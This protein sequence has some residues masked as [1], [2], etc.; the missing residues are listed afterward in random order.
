VVESAGRS[1]IGTVVR[2]GALTPVSWLGPQAMSMDADAPRR[3]KLR[4]DG[5]GLMFGA[6]PADRR[7]LC[8]TPTT[9]AS[10]PTC[11]GVCPQP[12]LDRV[13]MPVCGCSTVVDRVPVEFLPRFS[14]ARG[15]GR[16]S[17][18]RAPALHAGGR[19]FE[20]DR[21]H[22]RECSW[23]FGFQW[24]PAPTRGPSE[25]NK[26]AP[27]LRCDPKSKKHLCSDPA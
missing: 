12:E 15:R 18:G 11:R 10:V 21:L 6:P 24:G 7:L 2:A 1:V 14:I 3:I 26:G 17:V 13:V 22:Q 4:R 16:S 25:L 5:N 19:R 23:V 27:G 9:P 8:W 20:S